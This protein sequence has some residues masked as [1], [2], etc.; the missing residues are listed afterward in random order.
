MP[1]VPGIGG[2]VGQ[3]AGP[4]FTIA[5]TASAAITTDDVTTQTAPN[6][7]CGAADPD[8]LLIVHISAYG[9]T[10]SGSGSNANCVPS[11]VTIGGVAAT[12]H[13]Q[14]VHAFGGIGTP[15]GTSVW[16][17]LVPAGTTATVVANFPAAMDRM[18]V[19]MFRAVFPGSKTPVYA[20]A[21][22]LEGTANIL[23]WQ[24][25]AVPRGGVVCVYISDTIPLPAGLP[26][27]AGSTGLALSYSDFIEGGSWQ[28]GAM[29]LAGPSPYINV[30]WPIDL[31]MGGIAVAW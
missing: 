16:S 23:G 18:G 20:V 31:F 19:A 13:N 3:M 15:Y 11:S 2:F 25:G 29:M 28:T 21:L 26:D 5:Y 17:A 8:R 10:S 22:P 6:M 27:W 7:A 4:G 9:N 12:K 14:A 24:P 30:V 1:H